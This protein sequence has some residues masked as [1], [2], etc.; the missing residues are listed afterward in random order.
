MARPATQRGERL[1]VAPS[2]VPVNG[3]EKATDAL[4][5]GAENSKSKA[6]IRFGLIQTEAKFTFDLLGEYVR[7]RFPS[8]G[9]FGA[10]AALRSAV[11]YYNMR[12]QLGPPPRRHPASQA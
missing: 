3:A 7:A 6:V 5:C 11:I 1:A 4:L 2:C 10:C 9:P 8:K 12:V